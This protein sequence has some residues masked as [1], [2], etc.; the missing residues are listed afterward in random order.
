MASV[1]SSSEIIA[2]IDNNE[3]YPSNDEKADE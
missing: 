1:E 2:S 3:T